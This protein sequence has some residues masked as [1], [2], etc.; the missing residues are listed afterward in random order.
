MFYSLPGKHQCDI[1]GSKTLYHVRLYVVG[2][3]LYIE[4]R[5]NDI[6]PELTYNIYDEYIGLMY[7]HI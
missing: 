5:N 7:M 2:T 3:I 1:S 4:F 6:S